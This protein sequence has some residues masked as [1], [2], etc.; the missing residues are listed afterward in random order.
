MVQ[1]PISMQRAAAWDGGGA[2]QRMMSPESCSAPGALV[3]TPCSRGSAHL[4]RDRR[5][6]WR[7]GNS[8]FK[9]GIF[10]FF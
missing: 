2:R 5:A 3:A 8:T 1:Q 4:S 10:F 7:V 9:V 6:G